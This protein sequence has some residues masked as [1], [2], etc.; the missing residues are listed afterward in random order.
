MLNS[1]DNEALLPQSRFCAHELFT[2]EPE[3]DEDD[4]DDL[5]DEFTEPVYFVI[6]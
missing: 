1:F 4:E 2:K 3:D 6:N 5:D